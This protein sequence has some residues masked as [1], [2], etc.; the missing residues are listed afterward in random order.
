MEEV[1]IKTMER[2]IE[3]RIEQKYEIQILTK[4]IDRLEKL[5]HKGPSQK[6]FDNVQ[7]NEVINKLKQKQVVE[8]RKPKRDRMMELR[9]KYGNI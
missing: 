5:V 9:D 1:L 6:I 2:W 3:E 7:E 8:G 4:R